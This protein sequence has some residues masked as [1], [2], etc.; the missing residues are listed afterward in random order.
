LIPLPYLLSTTMVNPGIPP[1]QLP[2]IKFLRRQ[3]LFILR[4]GVVPVAQVIVF[5]GYLTQVLPKRA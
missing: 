1:L 2:Q 4:E 5:S 3:R